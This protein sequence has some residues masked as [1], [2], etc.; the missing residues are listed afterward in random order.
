MGRPRSVAKWELWRRRLSLPKTRF[1]WRRGWGEREFVLI[2][3]QL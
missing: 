2:E 3:L 1:G